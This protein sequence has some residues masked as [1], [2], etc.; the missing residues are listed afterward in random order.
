VVVFL[1][2]WLAA[3]VTYPL[4]VIEGGRVTR[5]RR[6][7]LPWPSPGTVAGLTKRIF[8]GGFAVAFGGGVLGVLLQDGIGGLLS[9]AP[10]A[11]FVVLAVVSGHAYRETVSVDPI[12]LDIRK[13][14]GPIGR[15]RRYELTLI[16]TPRAELESDSDGETGFWNVAFEYGGKTVRFGLRLD[17][18][19]ARARASELSRMV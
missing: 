15:T 6:K 12:A 2:G 19:Q 5:A 8:I 3:W 4:S 16:R 17:E 18:E 7:G 14:C 1:G 13:A 9:F 10:F 11:G